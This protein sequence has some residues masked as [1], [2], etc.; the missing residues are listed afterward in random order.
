[1]AV[2]AALE[3]WDQL[4]CECRVEESWGFNVMRAVGVHRQVQIRLPE[5]VVPKMVG[6]Q[7]VGRQVVGLQIVSYHFVGFSAVSTLPDPE[8]PPWLCGEQFSRL[9]AS[10]ELARVHQRFCMP[11]F[12]AI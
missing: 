7:I 6:S 8:C 12:A 10:Q 4:V 2:R 11:G 5:T 3:V 9:V 1:M